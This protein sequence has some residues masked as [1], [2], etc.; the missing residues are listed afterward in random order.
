LASEQGKP[1]IVFF[2]TD[3]Y[4]WQDTS[5]SMWTE[6]TV[7]NE[8]FRTPNMERLA[9]QGV[10]FPNAY[11][12]C[13]VCSASRISILTGQNPVRHGTTFITGQPGSNRR[14]MR[15]ARQDN[16]GIQK[17]DV[18][19]PTLLREVGYRT[20]CIGKAH[21][22]ARGTFGA[23][24]L[25]LGFERKHYA[26][27]SGSPIGKS[28]G[29]SDEYHVNRDGEQVHLTEALTLEAKAEISEAVKDKAPF[30]LYLSHYA[31]H[32]PIREDKRFSENYPDLKGRERAYAT[33]VEGADKSLGDI[34]DHLDELGIARNTLIVWTADNGGLWDNRP[35]KGLK[36]DAY[37]G[38]HRVPTMVSWGAQDASLAY[39][40]RMPLTPGRVDGHPFIHQDWMP[41]LLRL[42]G[43]KHPSPEL[44]D[45]YDVSDLLAGRNQDVRPGLFFW[46]EPNFWAHSGPESSIREGKWKLIY[47]YATRKW[48]LYDLSEDIGE[49]SDLS[50]AHSDNVRVLAKKLITHLKDNKA[51]YPTDIKSGE[52]LPPQLP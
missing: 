43:V 2:I 17:E 22:G 30:F 15:S 47:F 7:L 18:V 21:F 3:D 13:S 23:D 41:T 10:K 4:G 6:R 19:L 16:D 9:D 11:T 51:H 49:R 25:N 35:L 52:E 1:N 29:G 38:G 14:G 5:E 44:L 37:E 46:H 45:G 32:T 36:N 20:I 8:R 48:E 33:L 39:Q 42:V 12:A 31:V 40:K 27:H 24:P 28:C 50:S 34:L 26:N